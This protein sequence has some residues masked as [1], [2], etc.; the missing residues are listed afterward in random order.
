MKKCKESTNIQE[1]EKFEQLIQSKLPDDYKQFLL[2]YNGGRPVK[3][4]CFK[5]VE[6]WDGQ[7][8]NTSSGV[9][10]FSSMFNDIKS[11]NNIL[12]GRLPHEMLAIADGFCGNII[13][14]CIKGDN[15]GKVYYWDH[16]Y[17]ADEDE[18]PWYEN[19]YLIANSFADFINSLYEYKE[20]E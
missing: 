7:S 6:T 19:V 5:Y 16:E 10:W 9:E 11:S 18:E 12:K 1:I 14:L 2:K 17:E 15:Y 8:R 3:N 4:E 20:D 13:C